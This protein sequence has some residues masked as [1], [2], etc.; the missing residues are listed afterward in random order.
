MAKINRQDLDEKLKVVQEKLKAV[1]EKLAEYEVPEKHPIYTRAIER[2]TKNW[3][4]ADICQAIS[5]EYSQL[6][7]WTVRR[8]DGR[9]EIHQPSNPE[10][11]ELFTRLLASTNAEPKAKPTAKGTRKRA[12]SKT[13]KAR[14]TA[15][16]NGELKTTN[17]QAPAVSTKEPEPAREE[18]PTKMYAWLDRAFDHFNHELFKGKLH[19]VLFTLTR[20]RHM[21]ASYS[22]EQFA[23]KG[24]GTIVPE[25]TFNPTAFRDLDNDEILAWL[26][27]NMCHEAQH[28]LGSPCRKGYHDQQ[29]GELMQHVGLVPSDTGTPGGRPRGQRMNQYVQEGGPFA[30]AC[31]RFL[32]DNPADLWADLTI[33]HGVAPRKNKPKYACDRCG[34]IVYGSEGTAVDCHPCQRMMVKV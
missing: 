4:L 25:I 11:A 8:E 20:K 23:H 2:F 7:P 10:E 28:Q 16:P 3:T 19:K 6:I 18:V 21:Y 14:P 32:A 34:Q 26:V 31:E 33:D 17:G 15:K 12:P 27:H 1:R 22:H 24:V 9:E 13:P 30:V 5:D 29:W